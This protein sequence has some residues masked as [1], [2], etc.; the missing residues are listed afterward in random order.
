MYD[1]AVSS[2]QTTIQVAVF[3]IYFVSVAAATLTK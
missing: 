2:F 1:W 3:Q